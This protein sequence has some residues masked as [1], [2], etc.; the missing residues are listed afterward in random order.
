MFS[1]VDLEGLMTTRP[2]LIEC[3]VGLS[4]DEGWG[5]MER[6]EESCGAGVL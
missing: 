2:E 6:E 5:G 3:K 4:F 1:N